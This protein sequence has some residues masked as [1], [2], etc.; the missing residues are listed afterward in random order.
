MVRH[1]ARQRVG[2]HPERRRLLSKPFDRG[3]YEQDDP[4]KDQIVEWLSVMGFYAYINP[5]QYGIDVLAIKDFNDYGFEVEVK[6][7][8]SG[9]EFPYDTVHF[10]ARKTK[11]IAPNHY[12]TMFNDQ[13]DAFL[14]V[15]GFSMRLA[16]V[17]SKNTKYTTDERFIAVPV[18]RC[19]LIR[20]G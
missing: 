3:L 7:N 6:H 1:S 14:M 12:F 2:E 11:F 10:S 15:D 19:N 5:D 17:V 20:L 9:P 4:A 16:S 8:W 18:C 13:R